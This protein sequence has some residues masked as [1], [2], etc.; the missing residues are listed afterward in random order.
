MSR[1][2][3]SLVFLLTAAGPLA[4]GAEGESARLEKEADDQFDELAAQIR[5]G[6]GWF[7]RVAATTY[8]SEALIPKTDRDPVDVALRRTEALLGHLRGT[9]P[10]GALAAEAARLEALT[11]RGAAADVTDVPARRDLHR[12]VCRLRRKLAFRNPL[13]NF[14]K[15]LF[16]KRHRARANHMCD[17]YFGFMVVPGGGVCVLEGPF[18]ASPTVRELVGGQ[19]PTVCRN[20]RF[21]DKKLL[22]GGFLSP[23]LSYD[24]KTVLFAYTQAEPTHF[25]WSP[26]ST[27]HLFRV[28]ADGTGLRQ[29]TDGKVNDFDPC[30]LPNGRIVFIS[31][32][33]GG[34]GRCHA[35][36]VPLFT[37]HTMNADGGDIRTTSANEANEW[38]PSVD[39]NGLVV[40]TRWDYVDRG[41]N[42]AH[43]PWIT[44]PDGRDARA[45]HGN[46]K[47]NQGTN[48]LMEMDLRA[49]P[50]SSR[51]VATAAAHHDQAYGSLVLVDPD[52]ED[53]DH[54]APVRRITPETAFPEAERGGQQV[55][56]TAWPLD[57]DF[58]LCVYDAGRGGRGGKAGRY[59]IYLLDAFGNK[60]LLYRDPK[61]SCLSPIPLRPR[62]RPPVLSELVSPATPAR[63]TSPAAVA[64]GPG[65]PA[66]PPPATEQAAHVPVVVMNVYDGLLPWPKG[67]TIQALRIVQILPKSTPI[68]NVPFIG[69]GTDKGARAVLG[70]VPVEA[71]GSAH[72]L[73]PAGR[74]VYFQVLDERGLAVQSMRSATYAHPGQPLACQGC[75][76]RRHRAPA[77]ARH[78]PQA[79]RRA[80]STIRP[81]VDGTNPFSFP[82]LVQPVLEKH[83]VGCH[84]KNPKKAPD[85]RRGDWARQ[86]AK[87]YTSYRNLQK[88]AFFFAGRTGYGYDGW[89][90]PRTIPGRCGARASRLFAMLEKGHNKLKLPP[91]D[92][93]RIT[94]WLDCQ[95][96]FFGSFD[97]AEA[98]C[99]GKVV[100]P[101]LE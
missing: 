58:Y 4:T 31:E 19:A 90:S 92:L 9:L 91:G 57:E 89:T 82:R 94:L 40:Y 13:L 93:H 35:R 41:H 32:R 15:I 47:P 45:I 20:G 22:P 56:A 55:Y 83:C 69:Y 7:R 17:Q 60:E 30:W 59:G 64:D 38:H 12:A 88:H 61:I 100:K 25:K 3:L 29:L 11:S 2:V 101:P 26:R 16:V 27:W 68:H 24:G 86:Q 21:R 80:P 5:H 97:H 63:W 70:T 6:R 46:F 67:T 66:E 39:H 74:P 77:P 33:R 23:D 50:G 75:H 52:I 81:D 1:T 87:H 44:T 37:L 10:N 18:G 85:L 72:F 96:D 95:S 73:L 8:R 99:R 42:Q 54:M 51:Y 49:I 53:D 43:H 28:G 76:N 71:D 34:F 84:V 98:Q 65:A 62:R 14:E 78:V 48:P 36:P 79:L